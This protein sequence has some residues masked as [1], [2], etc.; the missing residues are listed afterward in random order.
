M[1]QAGETTSKNRLT[2]WWE[3]LSS[4]SKFLMVALAAPLVLLNVWAVST[5]FSYFRSILVTLLVAAL[6]AFLL[7]Y[8][9]SW[10]ERAGLKRGQAAILVSLV[11]LF[12][13]LTLGVTVLPL[14][15]TQAQQLVARLPEW[16][17][18]GKNQLLM[19]DSRIDQLGLPFNLDVVISQA[20]DRLKIQIQNLAGEA[21]NLT[22]G[23]AVFTAGKLFDVLLTI[24]LTFYLLQHGDEVWESLVSWLSTRLQIPFSK[25]LSRSFRNYFLGQLI[26]ATCM[27]LSLTAIFLILKVPF[28]LL[29]GLTIGLIALVPFGGTVGIALVTFLVALR[30]ISIAVQVVIAAVIVQQLVENGVAPRVLGS[31]TGLNPFWVFI[32]IL[33]GARVGGLLGVVVAVP[34][35]V[36]IKEVLLSVR[37]V[38]SVRQA[39]QDSPDPDASTVSTI[40]APDRAQVASEFSQESLVAE[41]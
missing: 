34:T 29:F 5:I 2:L 30:D 12:A 8:P 25:T 6:L 4:L 17:D 31:V 10:L 24:I 32:A 39:N 11:A 19:L 37:S 14:V 3:S 9:M 15:I 21:L 20:N 27:G 38:R 23:V 1:T 7:N 41:K 26:V 33:T 18:S 40:L 22:L 35:A 13:F 16:F 28:G 36:V